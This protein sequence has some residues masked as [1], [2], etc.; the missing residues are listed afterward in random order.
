MKTFKKIVFPLEHFCVPLVRVTPF[1]SRCRRELK[2]KT[3]TWFAEGI[4]KKFTH[5]TLCGAESTQT[6]ALCKYIA[7]FQSAGQMWYVVG[8][9]FTS[10]AYFFCK[11]TEVLKKL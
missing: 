2:A 7:K 3:N 4:H 8:R 5:T 9:R 10:E 1:E 6:T 11:N